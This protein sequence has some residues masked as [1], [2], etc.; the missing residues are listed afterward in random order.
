MQNKYFKVGMPVWCHRF[1]EGVVR[2]IGSGNYPIRCDIGHNLDIGFTY[3]GKYAINDDYACLSTTPL[4]PIVNEPIDDRIELPEDVTQ[5][6]TTTYYSSDELK[7][8]KELIKKYK[9]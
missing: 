8:Y 7:S 5:F 2:Q 1:G 9:L 3:D 6:L 4:Q